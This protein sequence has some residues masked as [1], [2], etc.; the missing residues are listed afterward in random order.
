MTKPK[1]ILDD[2]GKPAFAEI[3]WREYTRLAMMDAATGLTDEELSRGA[4]AH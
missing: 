2:C 1:V 4:S 3:S